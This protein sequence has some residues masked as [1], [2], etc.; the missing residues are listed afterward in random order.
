MKSLVKIL[1]TFAL[2]VAVFYLTKTTAQASIVTYHPNDPSN[3]VQVPVQIPASPNYTVSVSQEGEA[4]QDSFVYDS[5]NYRAGGDG[6]ANIYE[7]D[8]SWTTFSFSGAVTVT[9]KSNLPEGIQ[10]CR[11]LPA[12]LGITPT[13]TPG[14]N[15]VTFTIDHPAKLSVEMN[16]TT[17]QDTGAVS[18]KN[19]LLIFA[20]EME[21]NVPSPTDPNVIYIGP[22]YHSATT[23]N[24]DSL[25]RPILDTTLS[26]LGQPSG[27]LHVSSGQTVYIAGGAFVH[28]YINE[29]DQTDITVRGR[30]ILSGAGYNGD[31]IYPHK[32]Q[33][34][35]QFVN[36]GDSNIKIE[37]ITISDSSW[38]NMRF[39]GNHNDV[40]NV[41]VIGWFFNTDGLLLGGD[42]T[43]EN[44][45]FKDNDDTIKLYF[46][47]MTA[48]NLVI[49]QE[50]NG[51]PMQ[52]TWNVSTPTSNNHVSN[53]DIIRCEHILGNMTNQTK[54]I[55]NSVH[56]GIGTLSNYVFDNF[57]IDNA[58]GRLFQLWFVKTSFNTNQAGG[59]NIHDITF[60][61]INVIDSMTE[62]NLVNNESLTNIDTSIYGFDRIRFENVTV[63]GKPLSL[64][65]FNFT[66]TS[67]Q[68]PEYTTPPSFAKNFAAFNFIVGG[69]ANPTALTRGQQL[70]AQV[71]LRNGTAA[72]QDY[73]VILALYDS[74]GN[75][76]NCSQ[77]STT[78]AGYSVSQD[79]A[80]E[81]F[82][83]PADT[84][85]MSAKIMVWNGSD[86]STSSMLPPYGAPA[87]FPVQT[88]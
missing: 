65:T 2:L 58:D 34:S 74:S 42:S 71:S 15:T 28:G 73:V 44:S 84:T 66:P 37:G 13:F 47:N 1:F 69:N 30:G 35:I 79:L 64:S 67:T 86:V 36:S 54:G 17:N 4:P 87:M 56:G 88:S 46:S 38:T 40:D 50:V 29:A 26:V 23:N 63:Q 20:D 68:H 25:G 43:V 39:T 21:Q 82:T 33:H 18:I 72:A 60:R 16:G 5:K 77:T 62:P 27:Q 59:G 31:P 19:P 6:A 61:N 75:M 3:Q 83:L 81:G 48:S 12:R 53:V 24:A 76:V 10:T 11:I 51:A 22:G 32:Y 57:T 80:L 14:G 41:N 49:W 7:D 55:F 8:T 85:G 9:V 45:F 70:T 52:L 78:V